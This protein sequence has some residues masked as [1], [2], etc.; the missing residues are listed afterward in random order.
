MG[1]KVVLLA[2]VLKCSSKSSGSQKTATQEL[3]MWFSHLTQ[4]HCSEL[5]LQLCQIMKGI[6]GLYSHCLGAGYLWSC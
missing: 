1:K 5:H 4:W 2:G 3:S 6:F